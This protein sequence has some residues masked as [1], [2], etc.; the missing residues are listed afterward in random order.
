MAEIKVKVKIKRVNE[1]ATD[2]SNFGESSKE[3]EKLKYDMKMAI[4]EHCGIDLDEME[5]EL[6]L[7]S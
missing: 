6:K 3:L 2:W 1:W 4:F 7:V 5:I